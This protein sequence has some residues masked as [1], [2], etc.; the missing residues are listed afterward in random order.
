M[1]SEPFREPIEIYDSVEA[2]DAI[3]PTTALVPHKAI[4]RPP[5]DE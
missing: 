5:G 2:P 1:T 4:D 3:V